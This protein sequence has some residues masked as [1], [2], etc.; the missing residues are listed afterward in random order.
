MPV[1][2]SGK[3]AVK[4][5]EKC[6]EKNGRRAEKKTVEERKRNRKKATEGSNKRAILMRRKHESGVERNV[7]Q[8]EI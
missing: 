5:R 1:E 6:G 8:E 2:K 7:K 3:K 4:K